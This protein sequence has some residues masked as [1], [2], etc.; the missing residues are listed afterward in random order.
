MT[1]FLITARVDLCFNSGIYQVETC[2]ADRN[3]AALRYSWRSLPRAVALREIKSYSSRYCICLHWRQP[4]ISALIATIP[5]QMDFLVLVAF[6]R[7]L[8]VTLTGFMFI[9]SP[10]A[11]LYSCCCC[12]CW[13]K[14]SFYVST[15]HLFFRFRIIFYYIMS[16]YILFCPLHFSVWFS[17]LSTVHVLQSYHIYWKCG[18]APFHIGD[19]RPPASFGRRPVRL[20]VACS[21]II[22]IVVLWLAGEAK[23]H[24]RLQ[25]GSLLGLHCHSSNLNAFFQPYLSIRP[26][27]FIC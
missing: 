5:L 11:P 26:I 2:N 14:V 9:G 1:A 27:Y 17:Y 19:I 10:L 3:V 24:D 22:V 18:G 23:A 7:N 25:A 21:F 4:T 15:L 12:C 20:S 8:C 6:G 16:M 13:K